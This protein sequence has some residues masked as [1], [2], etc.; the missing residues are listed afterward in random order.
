MNFKKE[1]SLTPAFDM[2]SPNP[3]ENYGIHCA[4][5]HFKLSFE[6]NEVI[7]TIYTGWQLPQVL[8][9]NATLDV[10]AQATLS[11][12]FGAS[13]KAHTTRPMKNFTRTENCQVFHTKYCYTSSW[14]S[15][16]QEWFNL[17]IAKGLNAL[18]EEMISFYKQVYQVRT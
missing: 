16:A 13:I 3:A 17:L 7:F 2:R 11:H 18:W 12:G 9:E 5:L 1:I 15:L 8:E 6:R 14:F 4:E 10:P